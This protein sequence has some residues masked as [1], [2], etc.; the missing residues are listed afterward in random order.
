MK[1]LIFVAATLA[2]LSAC[3]SVSAPYEPPTAARFDSRGSWIAPAAAQKDLLYV[4]D[5]RGIVDIFTYPDGKPAGEL[6]GFDSPAGLCA[7][8]SG[9]VYVVDTGLFEVLE[10]KHGGT[11]PIQSLFVM[12]F[13]PYGCAVDPSSGDVAVADSAS[14]AQGPGGLSIFQPGQ[15]FAST[16]QDSGFNAYFFCTYDSKGDVFVDGANTNSYQTLFAELP[17]GSTT[18]RPISLDKTIGYPGGVAWNG[19]DFV[20]QDTSSR[21]L[22]R[23][24]ISGSRGKTV[25]ATSFSDDRSTLIHQFWIEGKTIVM[26]YGTTGR[27]LHKVGFWPY[28]KGGNV[29]KSIDV[30]HSTELSGV[31]VSVPK[32]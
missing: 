29:T 4:S 9:D 23:F 28:P 32:K 2:G 16:Y 26:P 30:P 17:N 14:Q 27:E 21:I 20:T 1:P 7:D 5:A 8:R 22:Y 12:G 6:K 24:K 13:F 10:Y 25:S 19:S 31:T 15:T 11:K 18:F 3:S